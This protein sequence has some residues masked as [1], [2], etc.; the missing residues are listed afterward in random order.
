M[1]GTPQSEAASRPRSEGAKRF[2]AAALLTAVFLF[3][4]ALSSSAHEPITT[5]VRF[6]KEVIRILQRSCLGCHRP[7]GIA[8]SLTTYDEAR[9]WAKA[10]K[11]EVLEKRMPPWHAVKGYGEFRNAPSFAQRDIDLL[12]NWVEGGAPKGEDRD[13]PE[14]PLFSDDWQ[15]GKPDLV[16]KP[17]SESDIA[18]DA[19]EFRTFGLS[20]SLKED[21]W[22]TA[23]DLK[24]GNASVV[25]CATI[26]YSVSDPVSGDSPEPNP[27]VKNT[28]MSHRSFLHPLAT[29][30][31]AQKTLAFGDGVGKLLPAGSCVSLK[32]HYR[33]SGEPAKDFTAVGLYFAKTPPR[34]RVEELA[35]GNL[36]AVILVAAE[37]QPVKSSLVLSND[38]EAIAIRP[39]VHP[40]IVSLQATAYRPDGSQEVLIWT[41]SYQFDW[42]P[43]YYLKRPVVLLKGTR[44]EVIAY[45]NNSADNPNTPNDP[46]K[47]LRWSEL[48][49][50][51]LCTLSVAVNI[52]DTPAT[53]R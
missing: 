53:N 14:G 46:P 35:I 49:S 50:E 18:A 19:D 5:K 10:I 29:W 27:G 4:F 7:G 30:T 20:P 13:L 42:E 9:P 21:R 40:L 23:I 17:E 11:E 47:Q 24:P 33:G 36:D 16:L 1:K 2:I 41:R 26:Y 31:P 38:T 52:H 15:L 39:L 3:A 48:T 25:H 28:S 37:P 45:L 34:K 43:T 22:L 44:I 8:F 32:I 6:N 12:V 51:P